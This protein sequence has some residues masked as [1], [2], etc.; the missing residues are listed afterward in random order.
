MLTAS[1]IHKSFDDKVVLNGVDVT[2]KPGEITCAIGPS[3]TGKT[4]LLRAL[5]LLD[6][7]DEGEIQ[8]DG[9]E[10]K[11]PLEEG[12]AI[13][14]PWPQ[15]TVVFQSLF[16]WPHLTLRENIM[17]PA[18]NVNPAAEKDLIGLSK[19]FEMDHFIDHYPNEASV[20]QKQRVALARAL[21]LNPKYILMDEITAALDI[22]QSARILTKLQHLKERGIG[23]FLI[24]HA[25]GFAKNAADQ[26]IFM[27]EGQI[28]ESG[29]SDILI[30]PQT[31]RL[32]EFLSIAE[33]AA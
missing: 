28:A 4:T 1:N 2:I 26:V 12:E 14:P 21:I 11:F 23:I 32:K 24:T 3:G 30:K 20:G 19:L 16:L 13:D 9:Q 31:K 22:E 25:I 7:P 8:M 18:R 17:L 27:D 5:G 33:L 6:Y 29:S 10:Y 15:V